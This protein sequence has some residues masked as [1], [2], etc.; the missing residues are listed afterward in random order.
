M[1][2]KVCPSVQGEGGPVMKVFVSARMEWRLQ[3]D[4]SDMVLSFWCARDNS[5]NGTFHGMVGG[6]V[7]TFWF[8]T[9]NDHLVH[10]TDGPIGH[11]RMVWHLSH[12]MT[13]D[14]SWRPQRGGRDSHHSRHGWVYKILE[15]VVR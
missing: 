6:R 2:D 15:Q 3:G 10:E 4:V 7:R 5:G 13:A 12:N 1:A 11:A 9:G 8:Y 14:P